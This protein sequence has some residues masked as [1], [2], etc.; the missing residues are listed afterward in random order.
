MS[1]GINQI[2]FAN[3][4][5]TKLAAARTRL[6][7]DKPFLGALVLRLPMIEAGPWCKTTATDMKNF[8]YN[9]A[10]IDRLSLSQVEFVLAHEAL[11]CALAHFVRRGHRIQRKWDLACDFAINP[12]LV[13][14]ALKP[15][16]EAVVLNQFENMSAEEI[17]PCLD[18]SLDNETLD[19]HLYDNNAE[20][21]Q[22]GQSREPPPE[23]APQDR[24]GQS[25]GSQP[26]NE[27]PQE[28]QGGGARPDPQQGKSGRKAG[29]DDRQDN[30][31][32][33]LTAQEREELAQKWQQH[34][35]SAAQQAQQAGKLGGAMARLVD[36]WLEPKL[37]WR[38]LLAHYFFDQAR[39][40]YN[41]MRPSRREGDM[42]L[43]S[44]KSSQCDLVVA[45]DTSGSIG[46]EEL[47]EFLSEINAIK[48]ALPVRITLLACDARL[49]EGGPWVFEPWE[50]FRLPRT[51]T[52]GGGTDFAPV[53]EWVEH[54]NLRP[55]ALVYFTDADAEFP[56]QPPSYPVIWLVKGRKP[57]PWGKRIQLN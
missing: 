45:I 43:P 12:I 36:A 17:Y 14:D 18:D 48:G 27:E 41:Y 33:P 46:E 49:A 47:S 1:A 44:L 24:Q 37:P 55:D 31:P 2:T 22:N 3:D 9:P 52:G 15:P 26:K 16:P 7:L 51:F 5:A 40:D 13:N 50:E 56:E 38:T 34:L 35:A 32:V 30:P 42:I 19:Q 39:N 25:G 8:Y 11:H 57:V 53:F 6:I 20:G 54:E 29:E 28:N 10:Y 4:P 23:D 21:A